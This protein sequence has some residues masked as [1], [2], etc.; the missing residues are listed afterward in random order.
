MKKTTTTMLLSPCL[1]CCKEK[2]RRWQQRCCHL[3]CYVARKKKKGDNN[4]TNVTF[5]DVLQQN[6]KRRHKGGSLLEAPTLGLVW[7]WRGS[8]LRR[9]GAP[10]SSELASSFKR[11][12]C[13]LRLVPAHSDATHST[14]STFAYSIVTPTHFVAAPTHSIHCALAFIATTPKWWSGR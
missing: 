3:C 11:A 1:L 12:W 2:K 9:F 6:K 5:F 7:V 13:I 14:Q 4:I 8:H 10:S